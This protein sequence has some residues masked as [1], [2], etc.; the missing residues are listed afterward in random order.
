[1]ATLHSL[2]LPHC[3]LNNLAS[4]TDAWPVT[5]L[6][7]FSKLSSVWEEKKSDAVL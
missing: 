6:L 2:M 4:F 1:M 5:A 3:S 7:F